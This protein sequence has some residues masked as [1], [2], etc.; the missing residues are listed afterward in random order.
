[1]IITIGLWTDNYSH[2]EEQEA[3]HKNTILV[4]DDHYI[5]VVL[6]RVMTEYKHIK[7]KVGKDDWD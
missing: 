1:M 4:K 3:V 6:N 5:K 7:Y 2:M